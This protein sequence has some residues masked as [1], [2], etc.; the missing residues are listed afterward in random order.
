ML[1]GG[2]G[3]WGEVL[4]QEVIIKIRESHCMN[5]CTRNTAACSRSDHA[6][7]LNT[8]YSCQMLTIPYI[9]LTATG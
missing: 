7:A 6:I 9:T 3:C 2:R 1:E 5:V 4:M 8:Y